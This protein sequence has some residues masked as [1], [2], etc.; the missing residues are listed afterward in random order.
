M[1]KH[2]INDLMDA[3]EILFLIKK[4]CIVDLSLS[5]IIDLYN[6]L[7][8]IGKITN[9]FFKAQYDVKDNISQEELKIF[10]QKLLNDEFD[11]D[12]STTVAFIKKINVKIKD[13]ELLEKTKLFINKWPINDL[14]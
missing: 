14:N 5:E 11:F 4:K 6:E 12:L 7:D 10:H 2:K 9:I 3:E 13:T 8:R 1:E